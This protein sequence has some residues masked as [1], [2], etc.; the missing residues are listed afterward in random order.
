MNLPPGTTGTAVDTTKTKS[1]TT[2]TT[3]Y[4]QAYLPK[5][6]PYLINRIVGFLEYS[7]ALESFDALA[8]L[9]SFDEMKAI[10][11]IIKSEPEF[12][13][14]TNL[15]RR[16]EQ[17]RSSL[18]EKSSRPRDD[19]SRQGFHWVTALARV[20]VGAMLAGF[21][22]HPNPFAAVAGKGYDI[23][24]YKEMLIDGA[25]L[26][27]WALAGDADFAELTKA[28]KPDG[29]TLTYVR[30]L[31]VATA[32]VYAAGGL[33]ELE[34][35]PPQKEE[36]ATYAKTLDGARSAF[37]VAIQLYLTTVASQTNTRT[38]NRILERNR[39]YLEFC[40]DGICKAWGPGGLG[41]AAPA[42]GG[43]NGGGV[44]EKKPLLP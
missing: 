39:E 24:E 18:A 11:E 1:T 28:F 9:A 25:K 37:Q 12:T 30:R 36:V 35:S 8:A 31:N 3:S 43:G 38:E 29:Q 34:L 5:D 2:T 20:E 41:A 16:L 14:Y 42:G 21:T 7:K 23:A 4:A 44:P 40:K 17:G 13:V 6:D 15:S 10:D 26:H 19:F 22:D 27:F 33:T 32:F